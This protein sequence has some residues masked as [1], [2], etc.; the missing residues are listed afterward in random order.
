[1]FKCKNFI[2]VDKNPSRKLSNMKFKTL[3]ALKDEL[4]KCDVI[5][6]TALIQH[7]PK[8]MTLK[9][10]ENMAKNTK[11]LIMIMCPN[12]KVQRKLYGDHKYHPLLEDMEKREIPQ[13][14]ASNPHELIRTLEV[15]NIL[16]NAKVILHS[17][18][19]RKASS[20]QLH[21]TR[22]DF[23]EMDPPEWHKFITVK[24]KN[25]KVIVTDKPIDY[26]GSLRNNYILYNKDYL[27]WRD[28]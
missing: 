27:G 4:P 20:K 2:G 17:C 28:N 6:T 15:V 26:Y 7:Y 8:E 16:T 25:G 14:H 11:S 19:A 21:F 18:L 3:D 24:K 10:L 22:S 5:I 13:L 12:G 1:M 23:P 9:I